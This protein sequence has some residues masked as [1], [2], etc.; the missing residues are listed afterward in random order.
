MWQL[1]RVEPSRA[2]YDAR[3]AVPRAFPG[4]TMFPTLLTNI[5][6]LAFLAFFFLLCMG[7][8]RGYRKELEETEERMRRTTRGE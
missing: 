1:A 7:G 5:L 4:E 3:T 6:W 8:S 2:C